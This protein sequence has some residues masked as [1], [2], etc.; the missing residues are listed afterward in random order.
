MSKRI[1]IKK[2]ERE[3]LKIRDYT[4]LKK[5][6]LLIGAVLFAIVYVFVISFDFDKFKKED[7]T[8]GNAE[9]IV[10]P[11]EET[12]EELTPV[13]GG[14]LRLS[15][16][17]FNSVNPYKNTEN[18]MDQFFRLV[19]DSLFKYDENYNLVPELASSYSI[20]EDSKLLTVAMNGNARWHDGSRV[21]ATDVAHTINV[22]K[23]SPSSPY[24]A[25]VSNM[26][27]ATARGNSI[28]IELGTP[29]ALEA[30][31]LIFPIVKSGS[32]NQNATLN[33]GSFGVVGNGMFAVSKYEKGKSITLKR[34]DSYY[35]QKP[36]IAEI[37]VYIYADEEIRKNM[38]M[39]N[40]VDFI[41]CS[42]YDLNKFE[43]DVFRTSS[44]QGR[45]F[46][47]IA[48]NSGRAPFD[49]GINRNAV[50]RI[51]DMESAVQDAYRGKIQLSLF[52]INNGSELNIVNKTI[53]DKDMQRKTRL[54]AFEPQR[55]LR[56]VTDK[57]D[58]M[59]HRMAYILKSD[60]AK[61]GIDSDV[62]GLSKERLAEVV[63]AGNFDIGIFSYQV[64]VNKDITK[65]GNSNPRL[66]NYN[67][68][69]INQKMQE[70]YAAASKFERNQKYTELQNKLFES[71]P[72][73][74]IGFRHD[75]KVYNERIKGDL[76]STGI[77]LYNGIE[78][79]FIV[80]GNE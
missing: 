45:K 36:H 23:N 41:D 20:S 14:T 15:V 66:F 5:R 1:I 9:Q 3:S 58:P 76:K 54:I 70:V 65:L 2:E 30:Y 8:S 62:E 10:S 44:Y 33:D 40:N 28:E 60:L 38:F 78:D 11:G 69:A 24:Y 67:Y 77:E 34:N 63:E 37:I 47:F 21:T 35:G 56:I 75:F 39:A 27:R 73:L 43:Y 22:I 25:L 12:Q 31:K 64:P 19:Y 6:L 61:S 32:S 29:N 49:Q 52:P 53:F 72:Y 13:D 79:I 74:G 68:S 50:A 16:T 26:A 80:E 17:R 51:L 59:K 55:R 48:F 18:S 57:D 4:N 46:D 71:M 42:Y 7:E